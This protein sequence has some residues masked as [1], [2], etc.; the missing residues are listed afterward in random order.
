MPDCVLNWNFL[1]VAMR[2]HFN[3]LRRNE[4]AMSQPTEGI[5][6]VNRR[7]FPGLV[8]TINFLEDSLIFLE[9]V[10]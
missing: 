3:F 2:Q 9:I 6:E 10:L 7:Y 5:D 8:K 4:A 1:I